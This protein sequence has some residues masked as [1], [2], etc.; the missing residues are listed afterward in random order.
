L[1]R[2]APAPTGLLH[3]GHVA[4]A[5]YVWGFGRASAADVL[6]RI[7]DHDRQRSRPEYE[8]GLLDD[9]D[10][11]GFV[12]DRFPTHT[13][14]AGR[15]DSRQS[16]RAALYASVAA[17]LIARNLVYGCRCSRQDLARISD[18]VGAGTGYRGTCRDRHHGLD[19]E[20]AW[21]VRLDRLDLSGP[22][23]FGGDETPCGAE[24]NDPVIRD[25]KGNWTYQF[26]VVVDDLHQGI[27]LVIRGRD[28]MA[29]TRLQITL[30]RLIGRTAPARFAHHPL[31]MK[32]PTSKL[33]KSDGDAGVAALR[34]AGWSA[35]RVIGHAAHRVGLVAVDAPLAA[36]EVGT[37]FR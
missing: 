18:A 10:W 24:P 16:D 32:S 29:S 6:L 22:D 35:A 11:L 15:C 25:R 19:A 12:P 5:I 7:E 14:R 20:I 27:D 26:A 30:G 17:D 4:S 36:T 33:S 1:T 23:L 34:A 8:K 37:L 28:L 31:I 2:F 9:L 21:R 3:L 13:F